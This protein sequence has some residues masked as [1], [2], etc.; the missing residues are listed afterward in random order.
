MRIK[1]LSQYPIFKNV[2]H[3]TGQVIVEYIFLLV[4]STVIALLLIDLVSVDPGKASPVFK[5]WENLL[6]AV[7]QDIST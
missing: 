7:G 3:Q 4:V 1:Q 5:Y 6:R 2:S